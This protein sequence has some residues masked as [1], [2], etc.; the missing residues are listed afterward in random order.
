MPQFNLD[1][2][3]IAD[4]VDSEVS[5]LQALWA[6]VHAQAAALDPEAAE[7]DTAIRKLNP[8]HQNGFMA[9]SKKVIWLTSLKQPLRGI[10]AGRVLSAPPLLAA[11]LMVG[12]SH[13]LASEEEIDNWHEDQHEK[14]LETRKIEEAKN[15][16]PPATVL[17]IGEQ[18]LN[19]IEKKEGAHA[20]AAPSPAAPAPWP[21]AA[22]SA[23]PQ[24][25]GQGKG[26]GDA[27]QTPA[28]K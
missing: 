20:A 17:Q 10:R 25:P 16:R 19:L 7:Y 18:F 27:K 22:N 28:A 3:L 9:A 24:N 1:Q 23:E 11:Q 8:K 21:A 13:R 2:E 15:P 4:F 14:R 12:G 5:P 26:H 6:R